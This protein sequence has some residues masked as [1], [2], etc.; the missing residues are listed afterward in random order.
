MP[1]S[2]QVLTNNVGRFGTFGTP[3]GGERIR[4]NDYGVCFFTQAG[5][6]ENIDSIT[7]YTREGEVWGINA[8]ILRQGEQGSLVMIPTFSMENL[9]TNSLDL[10]LEFMRTVAKAPLPVQVEAGIEGVKGRLIVHNGQP[11]KDAGVMHHDEVI[12]RGLIRSYDEAERIA[13]LLEFFKKVNAGSGVPRPSG[14]Y[15]RG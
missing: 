15:G 13:F 4:K 6:T 14:L 8:D 9:F 10:Y 3:V 7:Q 12:H 1:L 11:I 2:L 5:L